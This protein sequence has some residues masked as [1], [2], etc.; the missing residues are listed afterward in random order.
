PELVEI[1]EGG[2]NHAV[3]YIGTGRYLGASDVSDTSQQSIYA[4]KDDLTATG[5]GQVRQPGVLVE[6]TLTTFT[7]SSGK[8]LRTTTTN[9]VDWTTQSGWYVD[10]N[11]D[12][13]SPG[14]R[15]NVDMQQQLGLLTVAANVPNTNA[16][17]VGGYAWLYH[18]DYKT[19]QY[20][21]RASQH[22]AGERLNTNALVAGIKTIQ[23][24]TGKTETLVT[25]TGGRINPAD[26]PSSN[27]YNGGG[28]KRVSWRELMD[29][30]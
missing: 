15:V 29:V 1:T 9:S 5:L 7:G 28:A 18:F 12:N 16:C 10:L 22:A 11:P 27:A 21:Q 2:T 19:G 30:K 8:L 4:I 20:V 6:Q 14:E 24:T 3:V 17:N 25:D 23:L 26:D 13:E